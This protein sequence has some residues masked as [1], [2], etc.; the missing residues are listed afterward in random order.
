L[1]DRSNGGKGSGE[2]INL[3]PQYFFNQ[4]TGKA[5]AKQHCGND[6]VDQVLN[7]RHASLTGLQL[8]F[9]VLVSLIARRLVRVE[10]CL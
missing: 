8:F 7:P 6:N 4:L 9:D 10:V 3:Q 2:W 1:L 5:W